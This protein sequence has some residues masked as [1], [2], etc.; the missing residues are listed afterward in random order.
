MP[1]AR[2]PRHGCPGVYWCAI[3]SQ[4]RRIDADLDRHR[5][6]TGGHGNG[7][8]GQAFGRGGCGVPE[9]DHGAGAVL[10]GAAGAAWD[11]AEG[12]RRAG[13][14]VG[15][16]GERYGLAATNFAVTS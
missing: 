2:H 16:S 1:P 8:E 15:T 6:L 12:D 11:G 13:C 7:D 9:G 10:S 4:N 14:L 3:K 5:H